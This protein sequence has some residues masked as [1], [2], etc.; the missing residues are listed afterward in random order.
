MTRLAS[1]QQGAGST[2]APPKFS[3]RE[4]LLVI[5]SNFLGSSPLKHPPPHKSFLLLWR[6]LVLTG[7]SCPQWA[8]MF[9]G[10]RLK[11]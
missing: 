2:A 9:A 1:H 11:H 6:R 5:E 10:C 3:M 4:I 7:N 8:E